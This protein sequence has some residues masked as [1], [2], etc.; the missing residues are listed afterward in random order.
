ME[1]CLF[2]RIVVGSIPADIV[3]RDGRV[4]AFRDIDPQAPVHVL[5]IPV[6]HIGSTDELLSEHEALAGALVLAAARVAREQ[7]VAEDGYRVAMNTGRNGNQSVGHL[8]LHV[9]GGRRMGWPPG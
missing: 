8:H 6:A 5:V 1:E 7:G 2:C 4:L 9:L 3:Y